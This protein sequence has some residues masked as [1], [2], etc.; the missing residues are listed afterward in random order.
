MGR[1]GFTLLEVLIAITILSITF[2]W[3]LKAEN[4]GIDMALRSKFITTS[5]LLAGQR[6]AQLTAGTQPIIPG[7]DKGDFGD[8]FEGYTY[9]EVTE[10]T[11][12][13]G[14]LKYTITVLWKDGKNGFETEFI[15]FLSAS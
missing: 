2:V 7:E 12:I 14:Y 11:P 4:Q 9:N 10:Q 3:L 6:I 8:D 1:K 5:T 15:T 13:A